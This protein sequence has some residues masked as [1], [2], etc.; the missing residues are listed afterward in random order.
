MVLE[1]CLDLASLGIEAEH[2]GC[3]EIVTGVSV[4]GP[5][6]SVTNTPINGLGVLV[7]I[8][9]ELVS[10]T[11]WTSQPKPVKAQDALKVREQHLGLLPFAPRCHI[12]LGPGDDVCD[13]P[14]VFV[15]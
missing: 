4:P 6:R 5:R 8:Q 11:Q 12:G 2:G 13:V 15:D 7:V 10:R 14:G 1:M 3:K 9:E